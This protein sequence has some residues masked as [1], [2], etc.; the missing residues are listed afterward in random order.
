MIQKIIAKMIVLDIKVSAIKTV[1]IECLI[2]AVID[3]NEDDID[4]KMALIKQYAIVLLQLAI[5]VF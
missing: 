2:L 1:A 5:L 3:I 4:I